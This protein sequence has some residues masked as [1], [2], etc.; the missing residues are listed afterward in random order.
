MTKVEEWLIP[1]IIS[2]LAIIQGM[3]VGYFL[4]KYIIKDKAYEAVIV[5]GC[6]LAM[7]TNM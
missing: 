7:T 2:C 1:M 5:L 6:G 4:N 3:A